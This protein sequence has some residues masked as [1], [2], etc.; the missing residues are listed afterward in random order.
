MG[1]ALADVGR[2]AGVADELE[3]RS[4]TASTRF[5]AIAETKSSGSGRRATFLFTIPQ[6]TSHEM[7]RGEIGLLESSW[8]DRLHTHDYGLND[9]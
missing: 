9:N 1:T 5:Q 2:A 6:R 8:E 4:E 3:D 7:E